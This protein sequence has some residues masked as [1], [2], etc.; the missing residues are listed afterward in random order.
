MTAMVES[1]TINNNNCRLFRLTAR[2]DY[3]HNLNYGNSNDSQRMKNKMSIIVDKNA[4][5][6]SSSDENAARA[7]S[8]SSSSPNN[9]KRSRPSSS[10]CQSILAVVS[11]H[12]NNNNNNKRLR[13][14]S[15]SSS[16]RSSVQ[17]SRRVTFD[18]VRSSQSSLH[19]ISEDDKK[20]LWYSLEDCAAMNENVKREVRAFR[21]NNIDKVRHMLC[22]SSQCSYS[23]PN[24]AFLDTVR[25]DL[26]DEC[27]GLERTFLPPRQYRQN[28]QEHA[29][30]VVEAQQM[31]K[32]WFKMG[33]Q[34]QKQKMS[35]EAKN[36]D[37]EAEMIKAPKNEEEAGSKL[38]RRKNNR[39]GKKQRKSSS[40]SSRRM[41]MGSCSSSK[42]DLV[43][44]ARARKSSQ[45]SRLFAQ[46]LGKEVATSV[47]T[48]GD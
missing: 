46:L 7:S 33:Q 40:S 18:N 22:V 28:K 37:Q 23:K 35:V 12:T 5:D 32:D 39:G 41:V 19:S 36:K 24:T 27:R 31:M 16:R 30:K 14:N 38:C 20:D 45:S 26:P 3:N 15:S 48:G 25:L 4:V 10:S 8:F 1:S 43:I 13:L 34:E 21:S 11:V 9:R 29:R 6:V 17:S 44:A 42:L 2:I 47:K